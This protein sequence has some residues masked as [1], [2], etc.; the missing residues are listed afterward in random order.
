MRIVYG[1]RGDSSTG[2]GGRSYPLNE[3]SNSK[4][5]SLG[6]NFP[7][8]GTT[9]SRVYVGAGTSALRTT[10]KMAS[11]NASEE[12]ILRECHKYSTPE[13]MRDEEVGLPTRKHDI[14]VTT[15]VEVEENVGEKFVV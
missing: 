11:D 8:K 9:G 3:C 5:G 13:R 1:S 2:S 7:K 14:R 6:K 15:T 12:T 10:V 4:R